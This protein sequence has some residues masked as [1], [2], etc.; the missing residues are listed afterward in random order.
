MRYEFDQLE[1]GSMTITEYQA[2]FY[3]LFRYSTTSVSTESERF[4]KF[5]KGLDGPYQFS[6]T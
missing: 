6:T 2:C 3:A 5:V 1:I 4:K